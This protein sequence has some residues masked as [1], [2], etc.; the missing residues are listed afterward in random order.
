MFESC[1]V[2]GA[3]IRGLMARVGD[4]MYYGP[5]DM[6]GMRIGRMWAVYQAGTLVTIK[7][8]AE[9]GRGWHVRSRLG[10]GSIDLVPSTRFGTVTTSADDAR[11]QY[12]PGPSGQTMADGEWSV[13]A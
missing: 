12:L 13:S 10:D 11:L 6:D 1:E 9:A 4:L 5:G 3:V 8:T 2:G 7:I